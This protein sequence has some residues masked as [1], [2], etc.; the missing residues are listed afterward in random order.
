MQPELSGARVHCALRF[1]LDI[2]SYDLGQRKVVAV[3]RFVSYDETPLPVVC[4]RRGS[5]VNPTLESTAKVRAMKQKAGPS[6]IFQSN[7]EVAVITQD[8]KTARF[9]AS[10]LLVPCCLQSLERGTASGLM[11]AVENA[12]NIPNLQML[13]DLPGVLPVDNTTADRASANNSCEDNLYL[14]APPGL[15]KL[16][17]PCFAHIAST[18]QCRGFGSVSLDLQ[19]IISMRL[20]QKPSGATDGL[21][22][23]V[24]SVLRASVLAVDDL[25]P[26]PRWHP[27][28]QRLDI[29]LRL[30]LPGSDGGRR[31]ANRFRELLTGN[32]SE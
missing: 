23:C 29:L 27:S 11:S 6:N 30:C 19:G 9:Y 7:V 4:G 20:L 31:T 18:S 24:A 5:S 10:V 26:L 8:P 17:L 22:E 1:L 14:S 15:K 32:I 21:R 25:P 3:V 2:V 12:T 16:R 13:R 28:M